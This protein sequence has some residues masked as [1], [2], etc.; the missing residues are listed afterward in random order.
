MT[1][2]RPAR[3]FDAHSHWGTRRGYPFQTPEELAQQERVFRSKPKYVSEVEMAEHFRATGVRAIL[4][5]GVRAPAPID[6]V[7]ALHDYAF[8]TQ[9]QHGDV[10]VGHWLHIDPRLGR[11]AVNELTRCLGHGKGLVGLAVSGAGFNVAA[12]DPSYAPLYELCIEARAPVLI[13]V[14]T[15]GLGAGRPG[16]A[17]VKLAFSHPRHVDEVSATYP[18]LTIVASRPAWPW[19]AD[20][21]AILLHKANVWYEV[22]GWSPRYF[23]ADLKSEIARRLQDRVMFGADYPM[24]SYE[25]L[26]ADWQSEGYSDTVLDKIFYRN[27]ER[28]FG[29]LTR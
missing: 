17:G 12:S 5:L 11:L 15:T 25:R 10:I 24:F 27:A 13:M 22:H 8:D 14:G 7:R 16:G 19:Q 6:E 4:D 21:I 29:D 3:I 1:G 2:S 20:M 9:K 26:I 23:T 18:E 28:L